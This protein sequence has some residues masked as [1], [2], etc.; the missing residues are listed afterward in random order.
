M[1][2]KRK[3]RVHPDHS[4]VRSHLEYL[5][6]SWRPEETCCYSDLSEKPQVKIGVKNLHNIIIS[7]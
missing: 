7:A 2:Q 5:E 6:E 1:A 3:N 4:T